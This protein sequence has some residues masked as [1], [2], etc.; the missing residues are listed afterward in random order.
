MPDPSP[1]ELSAKFGRILLKLSGEA[2][3]GELEYGADRDR[4]RAIAEQAAGEGKPEQV[5]QKIADGRM[6]KW[7]EENVLLA[8]A[9]VNADRH[10]GATIEQLRAAL[11]AN[12]GENVI[13]RRF[14]RFRI[15]E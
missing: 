13:V 11:S 8:Q 2:L 12:T 7:V 1:S 9:H 3:M 10:D 4:I 5:Q 15:G 14:A 6:R